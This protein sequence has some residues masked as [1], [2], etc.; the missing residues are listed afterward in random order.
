MYNMQIN[1]KKLWKKNENLKQIWQQH[2]ICSIN[3]PESYKYVSINFES[4]SL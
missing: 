3:K 2:M 1:K 4:F